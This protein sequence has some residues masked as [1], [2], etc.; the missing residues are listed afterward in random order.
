MEEWRMAE[1]KTANGGSAA[2]SD[3]CALNARWA[4]FS[5]QL[6]PFQFLHLPALAP[7][8]PRF[9][10]ARMFDRWSPSPGHY[11][12]LF[13]WGGNPISLAGAVA[14]AGIA[15][16]VLTAI[17]GHDG[18]EFLIFNYD[19]FF[20]RYR[21]WTLLT[22]P[23][24]NPPSVWLVIMCYML[25]RF[26][27]AVETHLGRASLV[28]LLLLLWIIAPALVA[29][30]GIAGNRSLGCSGIAY[31]E[32]GVFLAFATLYPHAR[33]NLILFEIPVWLF[34]AVFVGVRV[35]MHLMDR[36]W[37]EFT[38]LVACIVTA[39]T[40][41]RYETG[42]LKLS[43]LPTLP[44]RSPAPQ[45][46]RAAA[47]AVSSPKPQMPAKPAGPTVDD[48]L[49]KISTQGMQSLTAE[50]RRILDEASKDMQKRKK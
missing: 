20:V 36:N 38:E 47:G 1:L 42:N 24:V 11:R 50:E 44:K 8:P 39:W 41:V 16:M 9:I 35:L 18:A 25:W 10:L 32:L 29:I 26:G 14:L 34:A 5:F 4:I 2:A 49:D 43:R 37:S 27:E 6:L 48:L 28:K 30:F 15:S 33:L 23:L 12:P 17:A 21:V 46:A 45:T 40:F 19:G 7:P 22:Y 13:V 3:T 31:I